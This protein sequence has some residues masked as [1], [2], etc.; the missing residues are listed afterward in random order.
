MLVQAVLFSLTQLSATYT[1]LRFSVTKSES[2][3]K[4]PRATP[5]GDDGRTRGAPGRHGGDEKIPEGLPKTLRVCP[6]HPLQEFFVRWTTECLMCH[7]DVS[8]EADEILCLS[9]V[10]PSPA[11][12]ARNTTV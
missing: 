4:E 12:P 8:P 9:L 2:L 11:G 7:H 6:H 10:T 5:E 1:L 3:D